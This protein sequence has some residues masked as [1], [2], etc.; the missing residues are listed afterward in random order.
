MACLFP[1]YKG[2]LTFPCGRCPQCLMRNT[3]SWSFRILQEIRDANYVMW[4]RLS[5]DDLHLPRS[6]LGF[7]TLSKPDIQNFCKRWRK[8]SIKYL[9][10]N[11]LEVRPMK[12]YLCGEYGSKF[13][14]PHYHVIAINFVE[15]ALYKS[16]L[17]DDKRPIGEIYIDP[18][19]LNGAA[20]GYTVG[21]MK[22]QRGHRFGNKDDRQKEFAHMSKKMGLQYLTPEIIAYHMND[23]SRSYVTLPGGV[24][25]AL[26]R[27]YAEKLFRTK[28]INGLVCPLL[29]KVRLDIDEERKDKL[30]P[31]VVAG[32]KR[33]FDEYVQIHGNADGYIKEQNERRHAAVRN[34]INQN[35]NR[36][37]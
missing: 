6:P 10:D 2:D 14:R 9:K 34:F 5:Y 3:N 11:H 4:I 1:I 29:T 27:Y 24:R 7:A 22:K 35:S 18:R 13:K 30:I 8:N 26:P 17:D 33:Q 12:Y 32:Q 31:A 19:P 16:W 23:L 21:Y 36:N 25:S 28:P 20:I 37:D 15:N